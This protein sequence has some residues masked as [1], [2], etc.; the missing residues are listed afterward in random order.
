M[1]S[2]FVLSRFYQIMCGYNR[3]FLSREDKVDGLCSANT[4]GPTALLY[5]P[6]HVT[7]HRK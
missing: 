2:R 1:I 5:S 3:A 6:Y 4:D 7:L